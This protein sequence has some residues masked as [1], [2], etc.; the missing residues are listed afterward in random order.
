MGQEVS[1]L[2]LNIEQRRERDRKYY[3]KNRERIL[4]TKKIYRDTHEK[5]KKSSQRYY[6]NNHEECLEKQREYR[7]KNRDRECERKREYRR[8][9]K[10]KVQLYNK[11]YREA[12]KQWFVEYMSKWHKENRDKAIVRIERRLSNIRSL[13]C[14]LTV[15]QWIK[16]KA[17]FDNRCA[18]CGTQDRLTQDHFVPASKSGEYTHNNII[19]ACRWCNA[20]KNAK[21]FFNWYPQQSFY[22]K[23]REKIILKFLG[24]NGKRQQLKLFI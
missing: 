2:I 8:I 17:Y 3:A 20:S 11:Q 9:N 6:W 18:Y 23:K 10:E 12:H 7:T 15:E 13:Q 4:A 21:D 19:P 24:Y 1:F 14:T 16:I 22:D 5:T